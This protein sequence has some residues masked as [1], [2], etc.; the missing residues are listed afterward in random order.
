MEADDDE[1]NA[2]MK[3]HNYYHPNA[4]TITLHTKGKASKG[5]EA[6]P[7]YYK[8]IKA[9]WANQG[10]E[11]PENP[12]DIDHSK[13]PFNKFITRNFQSG[14][15]RGGANRKSANEERPYMINHFRENGF[16][17]PTIKDEEKQDKIVN[18]ARDRVRKESNKNKIAWIKKQLE[19][20]NLSTRKRASREKELE[21]LEKEQG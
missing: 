2:I 18:E 21:K 16:D 7:D 14:R 12:E 6:D 3:A 20:P 9:H 19:N 8:K 11:I 13:P 1:R 10:V 5:V 17:V 15:G 4:A